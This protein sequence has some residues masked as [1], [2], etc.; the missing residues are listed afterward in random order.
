M[1]RV[2][3]KDKG[4]ASRNAIAL[5]FLQIILAEMVPSTILQKVQSFIK[6]FSIDV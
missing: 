6:I 5:S 3:P 2:C 1:I 4:K